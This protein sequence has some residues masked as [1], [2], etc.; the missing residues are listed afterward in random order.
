MRRD[1]TAMH[2]KV[3]EAT[4][5]VCGCVPVDPAHIVP[6]SRISAGRGGEDPRNCVALCRIHHAAFDQGKLDIL[7]YLTLEEQAYAVELV[8]LAEAYQRTTNTRLAA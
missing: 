1:W 7:P 8:G 3:E 6:R 2:S 5:R 4:C